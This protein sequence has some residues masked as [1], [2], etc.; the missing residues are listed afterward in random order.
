M[1]KMTVRTQIIKI[2][3]LFWYNRNISLKVFRNDILNSEIAKKTLRLL[4]QRTFDLWVPL[5]A[6]PRT[7]A[8]G[9]ELGKYIIGV[10][11]KKLGEAE[12]C[13]F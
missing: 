8:S 12:S 5:S 2:P 13:V 11:G 6:L 1:S 9:K 10:M 3:R 7:M 4:G